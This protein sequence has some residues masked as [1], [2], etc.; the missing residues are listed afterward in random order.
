ME[1]WL[2][3]CRDQPY[4]NDSPSPS[5]EDCGFS[6]IR[7]TLPI[8]SSSYKTPG[9]NQARFSP[10]PSGQP[11]LRGD[12]GQDPIIAPS[13]TAPLPIDAGEAPVAVPHF[14]TTTGGEY[15]LSPSLGT[16]RAPGTWGR[17]R[18]CAEK[19]RTWG[20]TGG[21]V[22]S[23]VPALQSTEGGPTRSRIIDYPSIIHPFA[24]SLVPKSCDVLRRNS[25]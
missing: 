7:T 13:A 6:P 18:F 9:V 25:P 5:T 10:N 11:A 17:F 20:S 1:P 19:K 14:V 16:L 24:F 2:D 4:A 15:F 8:I 3:V 22:R 21:S 12:P 23:A